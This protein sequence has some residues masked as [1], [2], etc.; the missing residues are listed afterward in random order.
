MAIKIPMFLVNQ[1]GPEWDKFVQQAQRAGVA[2]KDV[3][4]IGGEVFDNLKNRKLAETRQMVDDLAT[5]IGGKNGTGGLVGTVKTLNSLNI[6]PF[7]Y[8]RMAYRVASAFESLGKAAVPLGITLGAVATA[9]KV[10]QTA[11]KFGDENARQLG[12]DFITL[13]SS[14][15]YAF[16]KM[17]KLTGDGGVVG[18][19]HQKLIKNPAAFWMPDFNKFSKDELVQPIN[20]AK[21][22]K[23]WT[24]RIAMAHTLRQLGLE[25]KAIEAEINHEIAKG[26]LTESQKVKYRQLLISLEERELYLTQH[27]AQQGFQGAMNQVNALIHRRQQQIGGRADGPMSGFADDIMGGISDYDVAREIANERASGGRPTRALSKRQVEIRD[28]ARAAREQQLQKSRDMEQQIKADHEK[29]VMDMVNAGDEGLLAPKDREWLRQQRQKQTQNAQVVA[30]RVDQRLKE[31]ES[32]I[33]QREAKTGKTRDQWGKA[34]FDAIGIMAGGDIVAQEEERIRRASEV[35]KQRPEAN[36]EAIA[37]NQER[38]QRRQRAAQAARTLRAIQRGQINQDPNTI[39]KRRIGQEEAVRAQRAAV[40]RRIE[41]MKESGSFSPD[42]IQSISDEMESRF[43]P[44]VENANLADQFSRANRGRAARG[45][46]AS[47]LNR[48]D[49]AAERVART[50]GS[51]PGAIDNMNGIV[52][53]LAAREQEAARQRADLNGKQQQQVVNAI[54]ALAGEIQAQFQTTERTRKILDLIIK[55]SGDRQ[56]AQRNGLAN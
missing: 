32:R 28:K 24:D 17:S 49:Q 5:S 30:R 10:F 1:T 37:I 6:T 21:E 4:K 52:A 53:N 27:S 25:R 23:A 54:S 15:E 31:Q 42:V 34:D 7:G 16:W 38:M 22:G 20:D 43:G 33:R 35:A 19:L 50:G 26:A 29:A 45:K 3:G 18:F 13:G 36:P 14:A 8:E 39:G 51:A 46:R 55:Q 47:P 11:A 44:E 12:R 48:A 41:Q 2:L 56:R 9:F 40:R